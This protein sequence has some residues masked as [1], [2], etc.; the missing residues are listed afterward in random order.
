MGGQSYHEQESGHKHWKVMAISRLRRLSSRRILYPMYLQSEP[1]NVTCQ[2]VA[3][4]ERFKPAGE[5]PTC[6]KAN[7]SF[8]NR[9]KTSTR[10]SFSEGCQMEN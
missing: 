6:N 4:R 1:S 10:S 5:A 9:E 2:E 8:M 7:R 3:L